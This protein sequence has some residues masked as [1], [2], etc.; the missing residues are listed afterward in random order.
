ML[1]AIHVV[2]YAQRLRLGFDKTEVT[3]DLLFLRCMQA[4]I[5]QTCTEVLTSSLMSHV[6][7]LD[8]FAF[9]FFFLF[10][11]FETKTMLKHLFSFEF[12]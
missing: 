11:R 8:C 5:H 2:S 6:F 1:H 7:V 3:V 4:I 12:I 9:L 10:Y